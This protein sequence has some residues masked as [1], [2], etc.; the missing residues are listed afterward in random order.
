[1]P[2]GQLFQTHIA[3]VFQFDLPYK[4]QSS[5]PPAVHG[6]QLALIKV[7]P[8]AATEGG[9]STPNS[10]VWGNVTALC[11]AKSGHCKSMK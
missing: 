4:H 9:F 3:K 7:M 11:K 1:M 6:S 5:T 2:L 8:L 10:E